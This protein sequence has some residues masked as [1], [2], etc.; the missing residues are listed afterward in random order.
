MVKHRKK[1][2]NFG[3]RCENLEGGAKIWKEVLNFGSSFH[4]SRQNHFKISTQVAK[5]F[6]GGVKFLEGGEKNPMV[7]HRKKFANFGRRC[8]NL[9][10]GAKKRKEV[11][12]ISTQV[13]KF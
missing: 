3:R 5:I 11:N 1:F 10:G 13:A 4:K 2:A 6:E 8:E 7:K 9:E 12:E